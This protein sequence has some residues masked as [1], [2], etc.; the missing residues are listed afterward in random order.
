MYYLACPWNYVAR[1]VN[2]TATREVL[3]DD[4][5]YKPPNIK[6][7]DPS[8]KRRVCIF[9]PEAA[10]VLREKEEK[11]EDEVNHDVEDLGLSFM[12]IFLLILGVVA[13]LEVIIIHRESI[14]VPEKIY[15]K[16]VTQKV[17][18]D[19]AMYEQ[20]PGGPK[21]ETKKIKTGTDK[22]EQEVP[23]HIL[24]DIY[25]TRTLGG[26]EWRFYEETP[27][28]Y[29]HDEQGTNGHEPQTPDPMSTLK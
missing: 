1:Q 21:A 25:M 4:P 16:T 9:D 24:D 15:T 10:T 2:I 29:P 17:Y 27:G 8:Y 22:G 28:Q 3:F 5:D 26:D 19:P 6:V 18:L 14:K 20:T 13:S 11:E 12:Y 23:Q 7:L